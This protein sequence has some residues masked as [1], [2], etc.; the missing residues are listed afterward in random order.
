MGVLVSLAAFFTPEF[1]YRVYWRTPKYFDDTALW[2]SLACA[3]CFAA[4]AWL[5][6]G[7]QS[8]RTNSNIGWDQNLPW[9]LLRT[10]FWF[11]FWASI[12]GYVAWAGVAA[13]RGANLALVLSVLRGENG[14]SYQM[15]EVYLVTVSGVTTLTQLGLVSMVVGVLIGVSKGWRLVRWPMATLFALAAARA[16][17]NSERL[18]IIEMA[19]PVAVLFFKLAVLGSP[20]HNAR[21]QLWL[22]LLPFAGAIALILVFAASEYFRSWSTF[23]SGSGMGFWEFVTLRLMGYYVTAL[24]NGALLMERIDT[25]GGPFFTLHFLW[26][27]PLLNSLAHALYPALTL[28]DV[29]TDPY[30]RI[31]EREANPEFNNGSGLLPPIIDYGFAGALLFWLVAGL[32]CGLAYRSFQK[33]HIA[34]LLFYPILF[35]GVA[36]VAR[37]LYW[38]EGR[39]V[40]AYFILAPLAWVCTGVLR[41]R[42]MAQ[43]G[44]LW[45]PSH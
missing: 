39:V 21:R 14:A 10:A 35:T 16:L 2:I 6:T 12:A 34:G 7:R 28:D 36:E 15:K 41:R 40:T 20:R 11:C 9:D 44:I 1:M 43:Q 25:I 30:M 22:S 38:G 45:H 24:N 33:N 18:A 27:F 31:L 5:G 8:S 19:I 23:Y 4:G 17:F 37:I 13:A 32:I 26:R 3:V 42:Q 29:A